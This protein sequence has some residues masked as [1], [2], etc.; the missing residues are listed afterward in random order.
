MKVLI[1]YESMFGNTRDIAMA[2]EDGLTEQGV[3]ETVE[4]GEAPDVIPEDVELLIAGGPTHQFG[5]SRSSSRADAGSRAKAPLVSP[6]RGIREWLAAVDPGRT[7]LPVATFD[8]TMKSPAFL[9]YLGS[10][11]GRI[12]IELRNKGCVASLQPERFWVA[13]G[14]GP[15]VDGEYERARR[16]GAEAGAEAARMQESTVSI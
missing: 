15:L 3:V 1:V 10:A 8:T 4:V 11:S 14:D 6:G 7:R 13:G 5:M 9:K 2:I 12:M 16:W